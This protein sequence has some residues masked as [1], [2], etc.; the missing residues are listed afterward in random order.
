VNL[1]ER[2]GREA[3]LIQG[4]GSERGEKGFLKRAEN[5]KKG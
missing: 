3:H 2:K 1:T 5:I 4:L